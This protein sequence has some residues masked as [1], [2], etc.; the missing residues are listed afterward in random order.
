MFCA[1]FPVVD[2]HGARSCRRSRYL[3]VFSMVGALVLTG[4]GFVALPASATQL[5]R[6]TPADKAQFLRLLALVPELR[7]C[8]AVADGDVVEFPADEARAGELAALGF[9]VKVVVPDLESFYASRGK[10]GGD[11]GLYH[12][13]TE[14]IDAMDALLAAHPTIM[15]R[16]SIGTTI[17]GRALWVYKISDNPAVDED[18]PEIF[19]NAYIHARE[20]ITFEVVYNLAQYLVNGYGS[21][22]RATGLVDSREIFIEP[23]VNPD[24][25]EYN[26]QTNPTGGGLWRK[27]RRNNGNG[28]YGIDLNRNFS[29][30]WGYDDTGS[31]PVPSDETYRG[32][33]S[34][35]EPETQALR[36][37]VISRQFKTAVSLHSYGG[38]HLFSPGYS[39]L[40][41]N[42]YDTLLE[43][44]RMRRAAAGGYNTGTAW[45]I[46]YTTNGD[47]GDWM[48]GDEVSKPKVLSLTTEMGTNSDGFWP[49][50]SRIPTLCAQNLEPNLR[51]IE[52]A[53]NPYRIL[54]PGI[55]EVSSPD[56]V[57]NGFTLAWVVPAPDAD[58]PAVAWNLVE[59]T[60]HSVGADNLE[61]TNQNRWTADGWTWTTTRS[62]SASHSFFSGKANY[63]NNVLLS[64][65]GHRVAAG[66]QL[67]FWTWY[68][69]ETAYDYGYVE[70]ATDAR[71]FV[72]IAGSITTTADPNQRNRGNGITGIAA[73]W[74]QATFDLSAYVG[75]VIWVRFR[76]N[77]DAATTDT[78]WYVDDIEPGDL[79]ASETSVA[80]N[81]GQAQYTYPSHAPGTFSYLV[82]SIDAEG[83]V[84][85][86]GP[87][88]D[89][90]VTTASGIPEN[91]VEVPWSGLE[92]R[93]G[94]PVRGRMSLA[95]TVPA[96]ARSGDPLRLTIH[97]VGGRTVAVLRDE[98][99]GG[100]SA[101]GR[102]VE[103]QFDASELAVGLYFARLEAGGRVAEKKVVVVH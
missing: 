30:Y 54:P 63:L 9:A 98:P 24:G 69:T 74:A 44:G 18:E 53:D 35:S 38:Y 103:Q 97:D 20:V 36:D 2:R 78:G 67:K 7:D 89:M 10:A 21:D 79:F 92:L 75:Q 32:P 71:N 22:P 31:S 50:E 26:R 43:L 28:S 3:V 17:E 59:A 93:G 91:V 42:D 94:N 41:W 37:F 8:G 102:V 40:H 76:Y 45:E 73:A 52:L 100:S 48:T 27:N 88:K 16:Q 85:A 19:F 83:Q 86:W 11:F 39:N 68:R 25:V 51:M 34:F 64:R 55:A 101:P 13:Y 99:I 95:F 33:T 1:H 77:T 49:A 81:L 90:V 12:T 80:S 29:Q 57:G 56:T 96:S 47:A 65:R 6:V 58:N 46:L 87:P 70:V 14:A 4:L 15:T 23:V 62:H 82:Q 84:S 72:P 60:G 66:E 5:L 61:G